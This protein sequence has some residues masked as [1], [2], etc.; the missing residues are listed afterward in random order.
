MKV[1]RTIAADEWRA[2]RRSRVALASGFIFLLLILLSAIVTTSQILGERES[3]V[4]TQSAAEQ[5]FLDQPDRHPH[6]MVHYG[7][8]AFR[9]PPP[10]AVLDPGLLAVTGSQIFLEGHRQNTPMIEAATSNSGLGALPPWSPALCYQVFA[11]LLLILLG[12][13]SVSRE[14]EAGALVPLLAQGVTGAQ[15]LTG[16]VVALIGVSALLLVP[17]VL[18]GLA[19][20]HAPSDYYAL[21]MLLLVYFAYFALWSLVIVLFSARLIRRSA[22]LNGLLATWLVSALIVP[23]LSVSI[24]SLL[25]QSTSKI[26]MDLAMHAEIVAAGDGHNA[27]DPAFDRLRARLLEKYGVED[28]SELPVN[29]RGLVAQQGEETLTEILNKYAVLRQAEEQAGTAFIRAFGWL[30]PSHALS[31]ASRTLAGTDLAAHHRFQN[32]AESLRYDFVQ[33]LNQLHV[34]QLD[35]KTDMARNQSAAAGQRARVSAQNWALLDEFRFEAA[36]LAERVGTALLPL[37]M[38]FAWLIVALVAF[39]RSGRALDQ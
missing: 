25:A 35:Y 7:H 5:I 1:V 4:A 32:A 11:P 14:R 24:S 21:A 29:I 36:P 39:K 33:G 17:S 37:T 26:E 15:L 34:E 6:R 13:R 20:A 31:F 38:L 16:K 30:S 23:A 28:V 12:Y 10:L 9:T 3:R 19:V 8:Y 27:N 2:W 18:A 22:A